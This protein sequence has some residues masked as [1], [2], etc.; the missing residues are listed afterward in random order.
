MILVDTSVWIDH[1]HTTEAALAAA[2]VAD[3]VGLHPL[4]IEEL[5]VGSLRHQIDTLTLLERLRAFPVLSHA[6]LLTFVEANGL[7]GRGLGVVDV[8]LLGSCRLVPGARLWTRDRRLLAAAGDV[9]VLLAA[10]L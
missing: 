10:E 8:H 9:G 4:V 3:E 6:E 5:A 1:L 7:W 2:L